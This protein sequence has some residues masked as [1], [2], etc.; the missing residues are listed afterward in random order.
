VYFFDNG[1]TAPTNATISYATAP[2]GVANVV[3]VQGTISLS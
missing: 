1:T 2:R 3:T